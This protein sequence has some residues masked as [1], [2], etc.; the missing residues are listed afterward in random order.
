MKKI[1]VSLGLLSLVIIAACNKNE[2]SSGNPPAKEVYLDLSD[3]SGKYFTGNY[4]KQYDKKAI[5]GRV[6]FY[7]NHL[8][9]NNAVS[10]ASCHKQQ[11]AFADN[12][13]FSRGFEGRMTG[14]NSPPIQNLMKTK[15]IQTGNTDNNFSFMT[16]F[17]DGRETNLKTM[18][19]RP[20]ANHV[21]MGI[22]DI[23]D[24]PEKLNNLGYYKGLVKDAY[25]TEALSTDIISESISFFLLSIKA[26]S[27]RFDLAMRNEIELTAEEKY[28][29]S[30]FDTKYH[31]SGCHNPAGQFYH[32]DISS[33][34]IGLDAE[35]KDR[36]MGA[37]QLNKEMDGAFR[38]PDL[39][40]IALTAPYMHDGRFN[41]L[42]DVL[43]HYSKGIQG[44][45]NLDERLKDEYGKPMRMN[46]SETERTAIIAFLDTRTDYSIT[47][48]PKYS[49]PFKTK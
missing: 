9:L 10:C 2:Q 25:N 41:T 11:F 36:G 13:A 19:L 46:I 1:T 38:T 45:P 29:Q 32:R 47:T 37:V 48:E 39:T 15:T 30:L 26:D 31:C 27:S 28:G 42:N 8:S 6:L 23:N 44:H 18:V 33:S 35:T 34:N 40:N 14:R 4:S 24:L 12:A 17:W 20:V 3:T 43:Q 5:L 7:D 22:T 16:L 21:E 49:N